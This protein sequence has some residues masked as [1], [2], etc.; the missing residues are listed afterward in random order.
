M[1]SV[2]FGLAG[3][4]P[5]HSHAADTTSAVAILLWLMTLAV[6]WTFPNPGVPTPGTGVSWPQVTDRARDLTVRYGLIAY[7][8]VFGGSVVLGL[9]LRAL[10]VRHIGVGVGV[11]I[12]DFGLLIALV[13]LIRRGAI[14]RRD[15]G[16]RG[17]R[18]G[19]TGLAIGSLFIYLAISVIWALIVIHP[20]SRS[21]SL[22]RQLGIS[23]HPGA[24][25]LVIDVFAIAISAPVCEEIFF[26]GLLFRSLRNRL[27]LW[28]AALIAGC[29]FGLVHITSYPLNTIPI[30]M[31]FGVLMCLLYER[32]GS[33]LPCIAVHAAVDGSAADATFTGNIAIAAI[34]A[35]ALL[36]LIAVRALAINAA[37][38]YS[39]RA[40]R[41]ASVATPSPGA[42]DSAGAWPPYLR[43]D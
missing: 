11:L 35:A 28:P 7:V 15:L 29:L 25:S 39:E 32:T 1:K 34:I 6:I 23:V 33:L 2:C 41:P 13:P 38:P 9:L 4:K 27:P 17:T 21:Q 3:S 37:T 8:A 18:L 40:P 19:A 24:A 16:L 12:I 20:T 10:G 36:A 22:S 42:E 31:L 14:G 30:K 26:R 5:V 43:D